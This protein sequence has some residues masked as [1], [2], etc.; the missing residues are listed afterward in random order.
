MMDRQNDYWTDARLMLY[1]YCYGS[2][3][4]NDS[5]FRLSELPV[6]ISTLTVAMHCP[7]WQ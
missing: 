4:C 2:N 6:L 7:R 5:V 3:Q 1:A